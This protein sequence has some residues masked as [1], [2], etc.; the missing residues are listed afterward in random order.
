MV[1][2]NIKLVFVSGE[3]IEDFSV[4]SVSLN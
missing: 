1:D 3:W 2:I 4:M